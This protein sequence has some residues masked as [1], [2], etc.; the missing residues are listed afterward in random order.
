MLL[1][2]DLWRGV[3]LHRLD[4]GGDGLRLLLGDGCAGV[5]FDP[6]TLA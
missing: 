4:F 2:A 3:D 5:F 1:A 6:K